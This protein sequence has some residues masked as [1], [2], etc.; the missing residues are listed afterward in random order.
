ME[1]PL[2]YWTER[3]GANNLTYALIDFVEESLELCGASLFVLAVRDYLS[4]A[5]GE[6]HAAA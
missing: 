3:A 4:S 5:N 6:R 2:G 1:L